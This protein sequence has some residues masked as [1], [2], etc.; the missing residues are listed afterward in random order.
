MDEIFEYMHNHVA[1]LHFLLQNGSDTKSVIHYYSSLYSSGYS[2][3][4][5]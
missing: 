4:A 5:G 2:A 1:I 3:C